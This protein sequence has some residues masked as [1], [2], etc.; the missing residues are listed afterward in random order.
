MQYLDF[1]KTFSPSAWQLKLHE[2][3]I[4]SLQGDIQ[5]YS[6]SRDEKTGLSSLEGENWTPIRTEISPSSSL[7]FQIHSLNWLFLCLHI[8][9]VHRNLFII[10]I[11]FSLVPKG[12]KYLH[13]EIL[14]LRL[15][16]LVLLLLRRK[17]IAED[18]FD[19]NFFFLAFIVSMYIPPRSPAPWTK[20][21]HLSPELIIL[22]TNINIRRSMFLVWTHSSSSWQ[23][24]I[25]TPCSV[26]FFC[27]QPDIIM[28]M[29][30]PQGMYY[31]K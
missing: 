23:S 2:K 28:L 7:N 17:Y 13:K 8:L 10:D 9:V 25:F 12:K 31:F 21:D 24:S 5:S 30:Y 14:S 22:Y 6:V 1:S 19:V 3:N 26:I 15:Y 11:S 29:T 18:F 27:F 4:V 16:L 20:S